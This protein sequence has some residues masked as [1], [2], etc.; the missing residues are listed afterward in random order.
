MESPVSDGQ[1]RA[2]YIS[3]WVAQAGKGLSSERLLQ[4]SEMAMKALW[5][6][7]YLTLG[8]AT[9]VAITDRVLY[10]TA[11]KFPRFRLLKVA[12]TGIDWGEFREQ[13]VLLHEQEL[14]NGVQF[15]IGEF[16]GIV[17]S[18]TAEILRPALQSELL[19][20]KP[21]RPEPGG[22]HGEKQ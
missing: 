19:K 20:V 18:L 2:K 9:L 3:N 7:A 15:L 17:G 10:T 1:D 22:M 6:R 14:R 12:P 16:I 5:M 21:E 8:E 13:H 11:E 4:L